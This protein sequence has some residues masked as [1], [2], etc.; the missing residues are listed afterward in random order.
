MGGGYPFK[1]GYQAAVS[2]FIRKHIITQFEIPKR[3]IS[4]NGT[5]FANKK[6]RSL[7]EAY[8]IKHMRSTL[9]YPQGNGQAETTNR[10]ILKILKKMKHEYGRRWSSHLTIVLWAYRGSQKTAT[11]FSL[12]SLIYGIEVI[13]PV[14]IIVPT[15]RVVLEEIQGYADDTCQ[16]KAGRPGR[17]RR[18]TRSGKEEKSKVPAEN[19]K[20]YRQA[21]HLRIFTKGQLVL[22]ATEHVRKNIQNPPSFFQSGKDPTLSEKTKTMSIITLQRRI[23]PP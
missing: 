2:N 15:P 6:V 14:E 16:R 8:H 11:G 20:A 5:P 1:E 7:V 10:V 18:K 4:D 17:T 3:L 22:R 9:Y 23:G 12:F 19:G 13:N 21:V